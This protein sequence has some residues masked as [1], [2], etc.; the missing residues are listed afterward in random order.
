MPREQITR[1]EIAIDGQDVPR[2][3]VHVGWN[4]VGQWVQ[5]DLR[6]SPQYARFAVKAA[7]DEAKAY[8][9]GHPDLECTLDALIE[10]TPVRL[11]SDTL[12]RSEINDLI[13]VLRRAR[14]QAFGR[15]E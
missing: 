3:H 7:E 2:N 6:F 5:L 1:N 9:K 11:H 13:R 4:K 10:A 12:S 15:D 8:F 14:D